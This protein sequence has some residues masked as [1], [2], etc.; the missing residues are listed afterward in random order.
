MKKIATIILLLLPLASLLGQESVRDSARFGG[1][2]KESMIVGY[3]KNITPSSPIII[4]P[5][6]LHTTPTLFGQQDIFKIVQLCPGVQNNLEGNVEISIRGGAFGHTLVSLD[7]I[8]LYHYSYLNGF[9]SSFNPDIIGVTNIYKSAIPA[10]LGSRVSGFVDVKTREG[11]GDGLHASVGVGPLSSVLTVEGPITKNTTF[12]L[13]TRFSYSN[14][15]LLPIYK[16]IQNS[17]Q[18][19]IGSYALTSFEDLNFY[20]INTVVKHHFSNS[21]AISVSFF[22]GSNHQK[23]AVDE[24]LSSNSWYRLNLDKWGS[25]TSKINW[26][27]K[28]DNILINTF[29][30]YSRYKKEYN[31]F[32]DFKSLLPLSSSHSITSVDN[33]HY[34][35]DFSIGSDFEAYKKNHTIFVGIK[36]TENKIGYVLSQNEHS[37]VEYEEGKVDELY[38]KR[39]SSN[40]SGTLHSLS[41]YGEDRVL[42]SDFINISGG[43]RVSLYH[44][45]ED[46]EVVLEPR[47]SFSVHYPNYK[48]LSLKGSYSR[49]SQGLQRLV[50][51]NVTINNDTWLPYGVGVPITTGNNF[52]IGCVWEPN[53]CGSPIAFSFE[54]YH[55]FSDN[56]VTLKDGFSISDK[57]SLWG[58]LSIGNGSAYGIEFMI[59][60]EVGKTTGQLSYTWSKSL[61]MFDE[62]NGGEWF[63]SEYDC[64]NNVSMSLTQKI[65]NSF[66]ISALF[67]YKTGR[68]VDFAYQY[69]ITTLDVDNP[70]FYSWKTVVP[71]L[72]SYKL[73][74]FVR[75]DISMN[76]YKQ[77][78]YGKSRIN[79]SVINLFNHHNP[80]FISHSNITLHLISTALFPIMPSLGYYYE[81]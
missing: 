15:L 36:L 13:S 21:S 38:N 23:V 41:I 77:H 7:G 56:I 30:Y 58:E 55:N 51:S 64:R 65:G 16:K 5:L 53:L 33:K 42:I 29:L 4:N 43:A 19:N 9:V 59:R 74:P 34:I 37:Y 24:N 40:D 80:T 8:P 25:L 22:N 50:S 75:F 12:L 62:I 54:G 20:D 3:S 14:L 26:D 67:W 68:F 63:Y 73:D 69:I 44:N 18:T 31:N 61:N 32:S 52:S 66:D 48:N 81:F 71:Q 2:L 78:R 49:V 45:E 79:F 39:Y 57:K 17:S 27:F 6:H 28:R 76:V 70:T 46:V 35:G 10:S 60:K 1:V 11:R 72:N 47:V